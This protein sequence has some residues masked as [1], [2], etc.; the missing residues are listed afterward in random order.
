MGER[1]NLQ[2]K[3]RFAGVIR[4]GTLRRKHDWILWVGPG[5]ITLNVETLSMLGQRGGTDRVLIPC[6]KHND[7]R[8]F[9]LCI[10]HCV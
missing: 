8:A 3:G 7:V 2:G 5:V 9:A 6:C 1:G 10:Y 4:C